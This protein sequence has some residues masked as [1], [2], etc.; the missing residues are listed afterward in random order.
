MRPKSGYFSSGERN[1]I[2]GGHWQAA[3]PA[4]DEEV[5]VSCVVAPGFDF[6]DF[7]LLPQECLTGG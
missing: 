2:P 1:V 6:E 7:V 3:R 5:L 4:T